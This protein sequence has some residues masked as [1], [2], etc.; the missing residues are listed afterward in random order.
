MPMDLQ[1]SPFDRRSLIEASAGTGKTWTLS[2]LYLRLLLERG[3]SVR[4][5]LV[6]T[7]TKAATAELRQRIRA[8]L[9]ELLALYQGQPCADDFLQALYHCYPGEEAYRRVLLAVHGFDQAAIFTIHGFCQRALQDAAFEAAVDFDNALQSDDEELARALLTDL[10]RQQLASADPLWASWLVQKKVT[11]KTLWQALKDYLNKPWLQLLPPAGSDL[12]PI[13]DGYLIASYQHSA[14]LWQSFGEGFIK[15]LRAHGQLKKN[16]HPE[17]KL[18]AWGYDLQTWFKSPAALLSPPEALSKLTSDALTKATK[19]GHPPPAHPLAELLQDLQQDLSLASGYFAKRLALLHSQLL[20]Q[21]NQALPQRKAALRV[22][23]FDDLLG[24]L[25]SAL[26]GASGQVLAAHLRKT[27]PLALIDEFQ[28]TDPTQFA[29]FNRIYP[30][31]DAL[32]EAALCLVGDPK[33]AIYAFRGADLETYL[34]ARQSAVNRYELPNNYRSRPELIAALNALFEHPLPFAQVGLD[35]PKVV[36]AEKPRKRLQLPQHLAAAALNLVWLTGDKLT[37]EQA[38]E[39]ATTD[40]A[41]RIAAILAAS[42]AGDAGFIEGKALQPIKGGDIAVLVGSHRQA[43]HMAQALSAQGVLPVLRS[44]QSVWRSEEAAELFAVLCA[45]AQPTRE[46]LL[47]YALLTRL[48]GRSGEDCA[49]WGVDD[50]AFEREQNAAALHHLHFQQQG[51]MKAFRHWLVSE[52]VAPRLLGLEGGERRLTNLLHLAE[53]LGQQSLERP[54]LPA[55]LL[56]FDARRQDDNKQAEEAEL[57]LESDAERVQIVTIHSAKGLEYPLVFCPFLWDGKLLQ[58][59]GKPRHLRCHKEDGSL[60]VDFGSEA[61]EQNLARAR[62]EAFAEKLRLAY[63]AMT[64]ARDSLWL[65]CGAVRVPGNSKNLPDEGL[66]SSALGWLLYAAALPLP[67]AEETPPVTLLG[68]HLAGREEPSLREELTLRLSSLPHSALLAPFAQTAS[69]PRERRAGTPGQLAEPPENLGRVFRIGSFSG[70]TFGVHRDAPDRDSI[71][72]AALNEPGTGFFAFPRGARAGT[73]LHGILEDWAR[74][75]DALP[76]LVENALKAH[77]IDPKQWGEITATHLQQVLNADLNGKGLRLCAL[78]S[79]QRLPELG[80]C[81]PLTRLSATALQRLLSDPAHG[82]PPVMREAARQLDFE[83]LQGFL[84]GFIDLTFEW[85]GRWYIA[86]YKSNWLGSETRFYQ[87][88]HLAQAIAREHYYLQYLIY[89][90]ALRRFLRVRLGLKDAGQRLGGAF[91]LFLRGM[92]EAGCY[93]HRPQDNLLD[94]L[95]DLFAGA[96]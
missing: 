40:C 96:A 51:F 93:F 87:N 26:S 88:E 59:S 46:G 36:A 4:E 2:A 70:L 57:R 67:P 86:D 81:F 72:A 41:G 90:I 53:L 21:L 16:T 12:A 33:Q 35:Y 11:P 27:Y 95:D 44:K 80:F 24:Q 30:L 18:E 74:G 64:R 47:R 8:R 89:L 71:T 54:T 25:L 43:L 56:W 34:S 50:S 61:F 82:L 17:E 66:H 58:G 45:Y 37:K 20:S 85:Q 6:V 49:R 19:K 31:T 69:S 22:L 38:S 5:I 63:V 60:L 29:I 14:A 32:G 94:A 48:L 39:Q 65:Y 84:K 52:A 68:H 92:P 75:K 1:Q 3:L 28:D 15:D 9:A 10:W 42:R 13:N 79:T 55:L 78:Q 91:Y 77:A 83:T 7:Y 62:Q 76:A 23:A 73:C